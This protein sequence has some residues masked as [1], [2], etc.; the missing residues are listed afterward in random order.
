ML[1][2][3][4]EEDP[5]FARVCRTFGNRKYKKYCTNLPRARRLEVQGLAGKVGVH[6]CAA[7][8]LSIRNR[9]LVL[10][11]EGFGHGKASNTHSSLQLHFHMS[12]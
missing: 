1:R 4:W 11:T 5:C 9:D 7:F 3:G 10:D 6:L 12:P 8:W 2:R